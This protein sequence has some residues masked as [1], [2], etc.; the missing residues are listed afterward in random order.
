M[1]N[2]LNKIILKTKNRMIAMGLLNLQVITGYI[3]E[4]EALSEIDDWKEKFYYN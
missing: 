4:F 2:E 1:I 3:S